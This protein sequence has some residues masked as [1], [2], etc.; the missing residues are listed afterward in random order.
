MTISEKSAVKEALNVILKELFKYET[1]PGKVGMC[2]SGG[3]HYMTLCFEHISWDL[4]IQLIIAVLIVS[5]PIAIV[6]VSIPHTSCPCIP[7]LQGAFQNLIHGAPKTSIDYVL[8]YLPRTAPHLCFLTP[9][10]LPTFWPGIWAVSGASH[11]HFGFHPY[12]DSPR[13]LRRLP[14]LLLYFLDEY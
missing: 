7:L 12:S 9:G 2:Q 4:C 8:D 11:S 14:I 5:I 1:R 10:S 3:D 13:F 6:T